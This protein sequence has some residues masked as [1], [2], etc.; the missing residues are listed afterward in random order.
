MEKIMEYTQQE[1]E[2]MHQMLLSPHFALGEFINSGT[3]L[4]RGINNVPQ[5]IIVIVRLMTLCEEVLEPLRKRF[6]AIR[7]TSGYRCHLLNLQVGG[8]INSQHTLGEAADIYVPNHQTLVSY[9]Q[10]IQANCEFDQMILE[11]RNQPLKRWL[12]V[13]YTLRHKNR[14]QLLS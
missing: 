10:F 3:A 2:R 6:G 11:P 14:R 13:S 9:M 8:V 7:I 4:K 1:Q 5:D 12:H